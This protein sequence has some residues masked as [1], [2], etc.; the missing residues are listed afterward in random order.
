MFG[1]IAVAGCLVALFLGY[2]F[3]RDM[4]RSLPNP[5]LT[6]AV[7]VD[8]QPLQKNE[9]LRPELL[10]RMYTNALDSGDMHTY[11]RRFVDAAVK[12]GW[13][14]RTRKLWPANVEP[15]VL[16]P[17][18]Q[19]FFMLM[20]HRIAIECGGKVLYETTIT[21]HWEPEPWKDS[22]QRLPH[23]VIAN[24][25]AQ[26]TIRVSDDGSAEVY[27]RQFSIPCQK[28]SSDV[29][30]TDVD[31]DSLVY[32]GVKAVEGTGVWVY[33]TPRSNAPAIAFGAVF[34]VWEGETLLGSHPYWQQR[35]DWTGRPIDRN[36]VFIKCQ[37]PECSLSVIVR[38]DKDLGLRDFDA[39]AVWKGR[40]EIPV[41]VQA[42]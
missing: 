33:V 5:V 14:V 10:R 8:R 19:E 34:E 31:L 4:P 42:R 27:R 37:P 22:T 7:R 23:D 36:M 41:K 39:E 30:T 29:A 38:S 26:F 9:T 24:G 17:E 18:P 25:L 21:G 6:R 15:R 28:S 12:G 16:F 2:R 3:V 13:L 35:L 20:G 1:G 32:I 40:V 11:V